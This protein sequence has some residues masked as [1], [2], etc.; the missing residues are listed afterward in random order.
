MAVTKTRNTDAICEMKKEA[1]K[2]YSSANSVFK[3][4][5]NSGASNEVIDAARKTV[6][7]RLKTY[8][9][10]CRRYHDDVNNMVL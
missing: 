2:A 6:E 1:Y 7:S 3:S 8:H 9:S 10:W 4:I 5:V